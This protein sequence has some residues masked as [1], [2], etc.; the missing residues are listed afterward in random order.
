MKAVHDRIIVRVNRQQKDEMLVG[1]V[2]VK[3]A[4]LF[5]ANHREKSPVLA[6]VVEG[7]KVLYKGDII[8]CHH[9]HFGDNSPYWLYADLYSIP[10][11]KTIFGLFDAEGNMTPVCGN[12]ICSYIYP[13][14]DLF[15]PEE[16]RKP[17]PSRYTI[18][19]PGW[20][21][22]KVGQQIFTRPSAG[23]EIVYHWDKHQKRVVKVSEDQVCGVLLS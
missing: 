20:T 17:F 8:A 21:M 18:I 12:M 4:P 22:Y 3:M 11:N 14:S 15:L 1:G 16:A 23:Y 10:F 13:E 5:E 9:N 2:L 19:D 6:E 7:N